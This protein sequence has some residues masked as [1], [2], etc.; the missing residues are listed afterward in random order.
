MEKKYKINLPETQ[1]TPQEVEARIR[2][3]LKTFK[4]GIL[5]KVFI[6]TY[7]NQPAS[8]TEVTKKM[9][10]YYHQDFD[11]AT[12][13]RYLS[14][15]VDSGLLT[16]TNSGYALTYEHNSLIIRAIKDKF[17]EFMKTIPEQFR[18]KFK[19]INY[20]YASEYGEKFIPWACEVIGFK[21]K[22]LK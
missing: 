18:K 3:K 8:T 22:E 14:E 2:A 12:V 19:N 15:L 20:F 4:E 13:F 5:A 1:V 7:I 10:A 11:R 9:K 6:F 16:K 21:V 17:Q